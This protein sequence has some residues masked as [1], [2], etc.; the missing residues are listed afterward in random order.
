MYS[1]ANVMIKGEEWRVFESVKLWNVGSV[2]RV[3]NT[4]DLA[5][6]DMRERECKR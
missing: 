4:I 3:G 5:Y 6:D 2:G 1:I